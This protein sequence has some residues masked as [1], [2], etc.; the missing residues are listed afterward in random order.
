LAADGRFLDAA[1]VLDQLV[2]TAQAAGDA[3]MAE[4][5]DRGAT[6]LRARLN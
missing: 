4:D 3:E 2:E 5:A 1:A 6:R